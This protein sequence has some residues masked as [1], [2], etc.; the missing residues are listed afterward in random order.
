M[1][2]LKKMKSREQKELVII[3]APD[4]FREMEKEIRKTLPVRNDLSEGKADFVFAFFQSIE[5]IT[6][7]A[8]RILENVTE[9][10]LLWA[11]YPKKSSKRIRSD[12]SRDIGWAIF[13]EFGYEPVSQISIDEDWSAL[14]FRPLKSIRNFTRNDRMIL[15]EEGRKRS[16]MEN[17]KEPL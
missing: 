16:E 2:L 13:G 9:D 10:V 15:S 11:A 17:G 14:R 12:I 8:P 4:S 7:L 1:E 3:N 5:E 6:I